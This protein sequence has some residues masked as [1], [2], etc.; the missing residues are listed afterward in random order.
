MYF[1]SSG[2]GTGF[3]LTANLAGDTDIS[4]MSPTLEAR[5]SALM[6]AEDAL[7]SAVMIKRQSTAELTAVANANAYTDELE[8]ALREQTDHAIVFTTSTSDPSTGWTAEEN[9]IHKGDYWRVNTSSPWKTWMGQHGVRFNDA[10]AQ[11]A[12]SAA[13]SAAGNAQASANT[14]QTTANNAASSAS[15]AQGDATDALCNS[16]YYKRQR[17]FCVRKTRTKKAVEYYSCRESGDTSAGYD[18]RRFVNVILKCIS[19]VGKLP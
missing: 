17:T 1:V 11:A 10:Q 3:L 9:L 19:V 16:K 6:F 2:G 7:R 4:A 12:A 8:D 15:A 13:A 18:V 5:Q 14:A